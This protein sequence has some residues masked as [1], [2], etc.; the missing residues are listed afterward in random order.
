MADSVKVIRSSA[1]KSVKVVRV[2]VGLTAADVSA[3]V[4]LQVPAAV[5][6]A[7][8]GSAATRAKLSFD[9]AANWAAANPVL[10][11]DE[12]AFATDTGV[13]KVG[14]GATAYAD[15]A[16]VGSSIYLPVQGSHGVWDALTAGAVG[17]GIAND[18]TVLQNTL[19]AIATAGGGTLVLPAGKTFLVS[20]LALGNN[21]TLY[22]AGATIKRTGSAGGSAGATLR[23]ADQTNGNSNITVIGGAIDSGTSSDTGK[24]VAF[25]KV[26]NLVIPYLTV[27]RP[28]SDWAFF[29]RD[30]DTVN[31]GT[32]TISGGAASLYEDGFHIEGCRTMTVGTLNSDSGDDAV[33]LVQTSATTRAM[34]DIAI[35][36][37]VAKS[38]VANL[39]KIEV[40]TGATAGISNVV[41]GNIVG[42]KTGA[43]TGNCVWIQDQTS[44]KK[45]SNI[46]VNGGQ[47]NGTNS[48]GAALTCS[49]ATD[50]DLQGIHVN[51]PNGIAFDISNVDRLTMR[52]CTSKGTTGTNVPGIRLRSVTEFDL[53][54]CQVNGATQHAYQIGLAG[55][56]V[57]DGSVRSCTARS[58]TGN[59]IQLDTASYVDVVGNRVKGCAWGIRE[60]ASSC[61][62]NQI[63]ANDIRG[64]TS[65][66]SAASGDYNG[67]FRD[68]NFGAGNRIHTFTANDTSPSVIGGNRYH[69]T[70]N[71]AATSVTFFDDGADGQIITVLVKDGNTTFVNSATLRLNGATNW[72]ATSNDTITLVSQ[73][74]VWYELARTNT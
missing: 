38:A 42:D 56:A 45:I 60:E 52:G 31:I 53:S 3:Q 36:C 46:S 39:L 7:F 68:G 18:T 59:G 70:A 58:C 4:N 32:L 17:D 44:T 9:T 10:A 61:A 40:D 20:S 51:A 11:L 22:A 28:Y 65:A 43:T 69:Q 34:Y 37:I 27:Q 73:A 1:N 33:A 19:N 55:S 14:D 62:N 21:T 15:L 72:V 50:V 8:A 16:A 57:S 48:S 13:E 5:N 54:N 67:T 26:T 74:G 24:H 63:T 35:G 64:N 12:R 71:T 30:C 47:I 6:A 66:L 49:Y 2:T 29:L 23:N 41:I 25:V